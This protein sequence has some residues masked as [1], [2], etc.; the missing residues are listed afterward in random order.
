MKMLTLGARR[1]A[2]EAGGCELAFAP[3]GQ[4]SRR[5]TNLLQNYVNALQ[6]SLQ[7]LRLPADLL[8]QV[9]SPGT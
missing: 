6:S 5:R 8:D 2:E 4:F 3:A 9:K 7:D 1:L